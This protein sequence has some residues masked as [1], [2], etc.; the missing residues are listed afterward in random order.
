MKSIT[1]KWKNWKGNK[2]S[3]KSGIW[4]HLSN[5]SKYGVNPSPKMA[6]PE[7]K[8][9]LLQWVGKMY[10]FVFVYI[11]IKYN[12]YNIQNL[13]STLHSGQKWS[14]PIPLI[15]L[16]GVFWYM[17]LCKQTVLC[18]WDFFLTWFLRIVRYVF[19]NYLLKRY[20]EELH[21][22]SPQRWHLCFSWV[23]MAFPE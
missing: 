6:H 19:W 5:W 12:M 16:Y 17:F 1:F 9:Y 15:T 13:N 14:K 11:F 3:S 10:I 2:H 4:V 22:H 7:K 21:I 23:F 8:I 20:P 18:R